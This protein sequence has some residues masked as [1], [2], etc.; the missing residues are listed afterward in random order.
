[1]TEPATPQP[2]DLT[3]AEIAAL[4]DAYRQ[5]RCGHCGAVHARA[6]PRIRRLEFHPNG[7]IATVEF[8]PPGKWPQDGLMWPEDLPPEPDSQ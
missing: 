7:Q 8:W 1:L 2:D 5:R 3:P 6:C 4:W